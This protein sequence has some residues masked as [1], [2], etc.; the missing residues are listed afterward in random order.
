MALIKCPECGTSVSD[1]SKSCPK[2][3]YPIAEA[4]IQEKNSG[5][6]KPVVKKIGQ[7]I[8]QDWYVVPMREKSNTNLWIVVSMVVVIVIIIGYNVDEKDNNSGPPTRKE[9]VGRAFSGPYGSHIN[10]TREIKRKFPGSYRHIQTRYSDN[11]SI[12]RVCTEFRVKK[13][14]GPTVKNTVCA[15][16]SVEGEVLKVDWNA[17]LRDGQA[18]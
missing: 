3:A 6:T 10:L 2:C 12:I 17:E 11:G 18:D 15:D 7:Y 16:C 4:P 13:K 9:I 8:G 1:K 5:N 14:F